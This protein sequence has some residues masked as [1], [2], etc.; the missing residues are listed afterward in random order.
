MDYKKYQYYQEVQL[1]P[2]M[3]DFNYKRWLENF[4]EGED[5]D[6]ARHILDFF[7]YI[8]ETHVDQMLKTVVGKC[9]YFFQQHVEG[10]SHDSFYNDCW[11][12]FIPGD[13]KGFVHS[14]NFFAAK[15]RD[16]LG[17]PNER[18]LDPYTM[19]GRLLASKE[20]LNL[21]LVDD[22]VGSGAQCCEVWN[23]LWKDQHGSI[24]DIVAEKNHRVAYAPLVVNYIGK[25][26]I[27][28][29]TKGLELVYLHLLGPEYS[30][31]E[32]NG[33]CWKG[34]KELYSKWISL[35]N[36]II[37][38]ENIPE[39][40]GYSVVDAKG[41]YEQGLALAFKNGIPDACPAFFYWESETWKP[42]IK[43]HYQHGSKR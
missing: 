41:F 34:N 17:I 14:G 15:L 40:D 32:L 16:K 6:I 9:G 36:R 2:L 20:P 31:F 27:E 8:P 25:K 21:I 39:T 18:I 5:H 38:S 43:K 42:L 30:L 23:E 26:A 19:V 37:K 10:W 35:H 29:N 13:D 7:I 12:S 33:L 4:A 1:W 24:S 28:E 3:S 11:Y 22:F